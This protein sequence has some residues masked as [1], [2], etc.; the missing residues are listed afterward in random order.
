MP[1]RFT[2]PSLKT[3]WAFESMIRCFLDGEYE[4]I[5]CRLLTSDTGV[6]AFDPFSFPYGGTD[7]MKA[8]IE[9]F[10]FQV[11]GEDNGTGYTACI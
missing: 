2:N 5:S 9:A 8:L 6:L 3:S 1:Q 4:L 10:D 11:I 7:C